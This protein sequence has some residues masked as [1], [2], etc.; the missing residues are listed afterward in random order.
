MA[1]RDIDALSKTRIWP[2]TLGRFLRLCGGLLVVAWI[3]LV[4][5][6]PLEDLAVRTLILLVSGILIYAV[7]FVTGIINCMLRVLQRDS[8][9]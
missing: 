9:R 4:S 1:P 3:I 8:R 5:F 2:R 6:Y 7:G